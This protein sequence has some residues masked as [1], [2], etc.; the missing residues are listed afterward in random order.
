MSILFRHVPHS[1]NVLPLNY[2]VTAT[3]LDAGEYSGA[4]LLPAKIPQ[5]PTA[6]GERCIDRK[7]LLYNK[8]HKCA[9]KFIYF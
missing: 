2:V 9:K 7:T 5:V 1:L 4:A 6:R 8:V 3:S